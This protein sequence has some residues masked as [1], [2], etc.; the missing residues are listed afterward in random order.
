MANTYEITAL[1]KGLDVLSLFSI[2]QTQLTLKD[3]QELSGLNK[4]TAFRVVST[5]EHEG[6]L[7]RD[8]V[9]KA[10]SPGLKV[11]QLG[12][13]SIHSI[14]L[15]KIARPFLEQL[16]KNTQETVSLCVLHDMNVIYVDRVRYQYFEDHSL[17]IGSVLPAHCTSM[18]HVMLAYLPE[19]E[20][21]RKLSNY[22]L[23]KCYPDADNLDSLQETLQAI[24]EIG[25]TYWLKELDMG[26]RAV[27]APIWDSHAEV[28][29]AINIVGSV[30]T[31]TQ[32]RLETELTPLAL[33]CSKAISRALG[34]AI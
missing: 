7:Q 22:T 3:I 18:G 34:F 23:V 12:F 6:Y 19:Q 4:S 28:V 13:S 1:K 25:Y 32:E 9:S 10:Y 33:D 27:A 30:R 20:L 31:I 26:I 17:G 24:R 8:P 15:R 16:S 21:E 14:E 11:L 5:L 29:A 2:N